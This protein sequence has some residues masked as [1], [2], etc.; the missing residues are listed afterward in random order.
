MHATCACCCQPCFAAHSTLAA[1]APAPALPG[2]RRT[3][4]GGGAR[5]PESGARGPGSGRPALARRRS[6]RCGATPPAPPQSSSAASSVTARVM[7]VH[8]GAAAAARP[9][10]GAAA[11]RS[12]AAAAPAALP[13]AAAMAGQPCRLV[14]QTIGVT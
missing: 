8:G 9:T 4:S 2:R 3:A 14:C 5:A 6:G 11:R 7:L 1:G 13:T 10:A 12:G